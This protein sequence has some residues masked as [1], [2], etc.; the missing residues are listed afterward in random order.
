M[1]PFLSGYNSS[2][3][4]IISAGVAHKHILAQTRTHESCPNQ[5][6]TR[7]LSL[8][9]G[10]RSAS[11]KKDHKR[12]FFIIPTRYVERKRSVFGLC[13]CVNVNIIFPTGFDHLII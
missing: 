3:S 5:K 11:R 7:V 10:K 6:R 4:I 9:F 1:V 8:V 13:V 12:L 2:C